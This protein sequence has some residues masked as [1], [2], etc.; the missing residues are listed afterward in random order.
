MTPLVPATWQILPTLNTPQ[1]IARPTVTIKHTEINPQPAAPLSDNLINEVTI[2]VADP[3]QDTERAEDALDDEV[4]TLVYILKASDRL[5]WLGAK[6]VT[7][8]D[9]YYAWDITVQVLSVKP[10]PEEE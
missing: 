6:K 1:T 9:T 10:T 3:Q 5:V 2:T 7:I 8:G 4:L